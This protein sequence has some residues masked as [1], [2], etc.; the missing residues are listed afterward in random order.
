MPANG[1]I[2]Y[3]LASGRTLVA[4]VKSGARTLLGTNHDAKAMTSHELPALEPMVAIR[5][6]RILWLSM[7]YHLAIA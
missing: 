3:G 4:D 7:C 2:Q 5:S 6:Y 1:C